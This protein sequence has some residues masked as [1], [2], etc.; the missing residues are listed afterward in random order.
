MGGLDA[1]KRQENEEGQRANSRMKNKKLK[2]K[3]EKEGRH[4][5]KNEITRL[6]CRR[7]T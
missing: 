6:D 4:K 7:Y 1:G 2:P 3:K 5:S